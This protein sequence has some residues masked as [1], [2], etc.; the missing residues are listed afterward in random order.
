MAEMAANSGL[1]NDDLTD[2]MKNA[3]QCKSL[4]SYF[5]T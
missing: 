3:A 4:F 2:A 1:S 5:N